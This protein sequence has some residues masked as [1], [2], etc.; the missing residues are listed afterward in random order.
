MNNSLFPVAKACAVFAPVLLLAG[1]LFH[2]ARSG[3]VLWTILLWLAFVLFLPA[4]AGLVIAIHVRSP[5]IAI[6]GGIFALIGTLAGASMQSFFRAL[7]VLRSASYGDAATFLASHSMIAPT[8]LAPGIFFPIGLLVLSGG[9]F[10]ARVA[11]VWVAA[12]LAIGA[13]LFPIGHAAEVGWAL[14]T[15]DLL[16]L[17]AFCGIAKFSLPPTA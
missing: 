3:S 9:I 8:I 4:L 16:L 5:A 7:I 1:D 15:G 14:V 17:A 11:P 12:T 13:A 2:L 10:H 6:A